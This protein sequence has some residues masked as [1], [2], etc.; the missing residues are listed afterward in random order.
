MY[1]PET[2]NPDGSG[3][4]FGLTAAWLGVC[5]QPWRAPR[6]AFAVCAK[7]LLGGIHAVVP[8]PYTPVHPGE[9]LWAAASLSAGLRVRVIG[10]LLA[11]VGGE[12]LVPITRTRF[13]SHD[14][15]SGDATVFQE[16]SVGIMGFAGLGASIP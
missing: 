10:P 5:A 11:E 1:L 15:Q 7:S 9:R 6:A 8:G 2:P 16:K 3:F 4:A 14:A 13:A 12:L